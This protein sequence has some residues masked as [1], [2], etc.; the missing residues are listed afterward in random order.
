MS[1]FVDGMQPRHRIGLQ[2]PGRDLFIAYPRDI[3]EPENIRIDAPTVVGNFSRAERTATIVENP[4]GD[5]AGNC[6]S[7]RI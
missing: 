5:G 2:Q 1:M 7:T 3:F 6:R 4:W